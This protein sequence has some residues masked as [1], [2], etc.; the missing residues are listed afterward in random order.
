[1]SRLPLHRRR[2][3]DRQPGNGKSEKLSL[4][5]SNQLSYQTARTSFACFFFCPPQSLRP[6]PESVS[7]VPVGQGPCHKRGLAA[8][9]SVEHGAFLAY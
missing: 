6:R 9:H 8:S 1:M 5:L 2:K 3:T 7:K 4:D